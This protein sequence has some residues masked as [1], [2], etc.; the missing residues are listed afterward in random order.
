[1]LYLSQID[2]HY[3]SSSTWIECKRQRMPSSQRIAKD[4]FVSIKVGLRVGN[5][6]GATTV[7]R[8]KPA[9]SFLVIL[10]LGDSTDFKYNLLSEF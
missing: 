7:S 1:M 9:A 8:H 3:G 5:W 6:A 10:D 2:D 4:V